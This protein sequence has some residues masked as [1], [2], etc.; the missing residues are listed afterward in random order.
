MAS[1]NYLKNQTNWIQINRSDPS[2]WGNPSPPRT[3]VAPMNMDKMKSEFWWIRRSR[4]LAR[5]LSWTT[6]KPTRLS[7]CRTWQLRS[8]TRGA[9]R[10]RVA[11][12]SPG[13]PR[14][15]W[16]WPANQHTKFWM[17]DRRKTGGHRRILVPKARMTSD[18]TSFKA[19]RFPSK[20][21]IA[22]QIWCKALLPFLCWTTTNIRRIRPWCGAAKIM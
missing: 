6:Y 13:R 16:L 5:S 12:T 17:I 21:I 7:P 15:T 10:L 20:W 9:R 14:I 3:E 2:K 18:D 4:S 1:T 19:I 8:K 22:C 11:T